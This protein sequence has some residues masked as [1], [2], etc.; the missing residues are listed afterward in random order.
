MYG[1][2]FRTFGAASQKDGD[3]DA[4]LRLDLGP[5]TNVLVGE[6]DSGK[7]AIVDAIRLCLLTTA[8]DFYRIARDDFHVGPDGRAGTFTI[9]CCRPRSSGPRSRPAAL[10]LLAAPGPRPRYQAVTPGRAHRPD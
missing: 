10:F 4:S 6:N 7:S 2:N 5:A 9:T 1:K 3:K 8:A